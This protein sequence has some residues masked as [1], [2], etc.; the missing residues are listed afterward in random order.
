MNS[1]NGIRFNEKIPARNSEYTFKVTE[2]YRWDEKEQVVN[3]D[4][5]IPADAVKFRENNGL[6]ELEVH[7]NAF[8][9]QRKKERELGCEILIYPNFGA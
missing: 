4:V 2:I 1:V 8:E 9:N 7:N 6:Y 5:K 3:F